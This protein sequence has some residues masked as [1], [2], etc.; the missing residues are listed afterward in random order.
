MRAL[1]LEV[2]KGHTV[3][4]ASE[5]IGKSR[6]YC[7]QLGK[8]PE[9]AKMVEEAAAELRKNETVATAHTR[10][11]VDSQMRRVYEWC[12]GTRQVAAPC[13]KCEQKFEKLRDT[14]HAVKLLEMF[15]LEQGMFKRQLDVTSRKGGMIEGGEMQILGQFAALLDRLGSVTTA[16]VLKMI[17]EENLRGALRINGY[18]IERENGK[19]DGNIVRAE[20][21]AVD[22]R[23]GR[24]SDAQP[25]LALS[26]AAPLS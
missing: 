23:E 26:E 12:I 15:G 1:A 14:K 17:S 24:E 10:G 3:A 20:G 22:G 5:I 9:F 21:D 11:W 7:W 25:V 2:A 13:K 18:R 19:S 8:K 6:S 16:K 4:A